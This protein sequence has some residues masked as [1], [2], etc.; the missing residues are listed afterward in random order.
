METNP[1]K[2]RQHFYRVQ[3]TPQISVSPTLQL[4]IDPVRNPDEDEIWVLGFRS[5]FAF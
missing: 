5:R 3:V 1:R 4:I 2:Q